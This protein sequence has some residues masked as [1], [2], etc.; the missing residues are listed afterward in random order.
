LGIRDKGAKKTSIIG[1][2]TSK[3]THILNKIALK[4][5]NKEKAGNIID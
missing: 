5:S 1:L 3:T 2:L 4:Q